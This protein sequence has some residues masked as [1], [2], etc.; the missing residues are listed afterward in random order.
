V[1][2]NTEYSREF[3]F[4]FSSETL[5]ALIVNLNSSG[6]RSF[7]PF[8][9]ISAHALAEGA[10]SRE[11]RQVFETGRL[12][13]DSKPLS[14]Y[15][16]RFIKITPQVRGTDFM[17]EFLLQAPTGSRHFFLGGTVETLQGLEDFI[18]KN[19]GDELN[20]IFESP[21]FEVPWSESSEFWI[22]RI[23]TARPNF[24]WV[25]MGA[26]KQF[27]IAAD[28]IPYRFPL[29]RLVPLSISSQ[30]VNVNARAQ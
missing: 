24:V 13:C 30:V 11:L 10:K 6:L 1:R 23:D 3:Y 4:K 18:K 8:H 27:Y 20:C 16:S 7:P 19:R 15:L 2:V 12:I 29:F 17:K 9:F 28:I 21:D 14:I 5:S 26:P 25:G 22:S